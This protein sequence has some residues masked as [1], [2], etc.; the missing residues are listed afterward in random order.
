MKHVQT[1]LV[2]GLLSLV[3]VSAQEPRTE[4]TKWQDG[5]LAAVSMTYDD[6]TINQFRVA[7]PMMN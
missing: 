7:L 6:S 1:A 4:I 2:T 5:K 3:S